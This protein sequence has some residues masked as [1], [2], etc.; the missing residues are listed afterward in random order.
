MY[1]GEHSSVETRICSVQARTVWKRGGKRRVLSEC[2]MQQR[3]PQF[4]GS[5]RRTCA[6]YEP[7]HLIQPGMNDESPHCEGP[8]SSPCD[9]NF[10]GGV[11]G[12]WEMG[13]LAALRWRSVG[14]SAEELV[15]LNLF[16]Q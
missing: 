3:V 16:L 14:L 8:H 10:L 9:K 11:R 7:A 2:K 4:G 1:F 5:W 6:W 15:G 13:A 12:E